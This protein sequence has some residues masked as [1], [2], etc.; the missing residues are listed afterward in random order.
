M[1]DFVEE[2]SEDFGSARGVGDLGVKLQAEYVALA[3]LYG[4][5]GAGGG[6]GE[7][8]E[9]FGKLIDLVAMAH[10]D[11]CFRGYALEK[12]VFVENGELCPAILASGR[13]G[14]V[15]TEGLADN[16]HAVADA[17]NW[18]SECK[19]FGVGFGSVLF[20]DAGGSAGK[21]DAGWCHLAKLIGGDFGTDQQRIDVLLSHSACD[22]L[23]VL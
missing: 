15:S 2:I 22:E 12:A 9:V 18:Y 20:V 13:G 6:S 17:E 3:V 11:G 21:D 7:R 8:F 23:A 4:G 1:A 14:D 10:P 16:L 19:D 5:S